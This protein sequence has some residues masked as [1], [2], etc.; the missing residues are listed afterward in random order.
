MCDQSCMYKSEK[1]L[2]S[3]SIDC[4]RIQSLLLWV[5]HHQKNQLLQTLRW[6]FLGPLVVGIHMFSPENQFVMNHHPIVLNKNKYQVYKKK[7]LLSKKVIN[8]LIVM[9]FIEFWKCK[10]FFI[11]T[12]FI[13]VKKYQNTNLTQTWKMPS[14]SISPSAK[15]IVFSTK[16]PVVILC[17]C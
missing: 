10:R 12:K 13:L 14:N 4:K 7:K 5:N 3:L 15:T 8:I 17:S 2:I 11:S 6:T 16:N 1:C 9:F